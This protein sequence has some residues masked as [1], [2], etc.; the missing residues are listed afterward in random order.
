MNKR[1]F[2]GFPADAAPPTKKKNQRIENRFEVNEN[3]TVRIRQV[4]VPATKSDV[5]P[6]STH[7]PYSPYSLDVPQPHPALPAYVRASSAASHRNSSPHGATALER[8]SQDPVSLCAPLSTPA[9]ECATTHAATA[10]PYLSHLYPYPYPC[11]PR[12]QAALDANPLPP[13]LSTVSPASHP[14]LNP[15]RPC[16]RS[17]AAFVPSTPAL[18]PRS[19][20]GILFVNDVMLNELLNCGSELAATQLDIHLM[21]FDDTPG[22]LI[23][24][25]ECGCGPA[26]HTCDNEQPSWTSPDRIKILV[27][28]I[29]A[30][31]RHTAVRHLGVYVRPHTGG[32]NHSSRTLCRWNGQLFPVLQRH[33]ESAL[34]GRKGIMHTL[35]VIGPNTRHD[36]DTRGCRQNPYARTSPPQ[37]AGLASSGCPPRC[38]RLRPWPPGSPAPGI[39]T[40]AVASPSPAPGIPTAAV[41]SPSPAPGIPTPA[42][43]SPASA[44]C[45]PIP[46]ISSPAPAPGMPIPAVA[47]PAPSISTTSVGLASPA[48]SAPTLVASPAPGIPTAAAASVA[49]ASPVCVVA[50]P[51]PGIPTA[52]AAHVASA[53]PAPGV[54]CLPVTSV[55]STSTLAAVLV[56]SNSPAE[57]LHP[58]PVSS[59]ASPPVHLQQPQE[60]RPV[61]VPPA[62]PPPLQLGEVAPGT[63]HLWEHYTH[64]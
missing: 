59:P 9:P 19:K 58:L 43:A 17:P 37:P 63:T 47:S 18:F 24:L 22:V 50:S 53:S 41:A 21:S 12:P 34:R 60:Y 14:V 33:F 57:G 3:D 30:C 31:V 25:N 2:P 15:V 8:E 56:A 35:C 44:P 42:V 7:V 45:I 4:T 11:P 20:N 40:A 5:L 61:I 48:A 28:F 51:A 38:P 55:Q 49:S 26:Q 29:V 39:P 16:A 27:T 10:T 13:F 1:I 54:P 46:T 6:S 36:C 52:A 23:I 32:Q 64:P 62:P